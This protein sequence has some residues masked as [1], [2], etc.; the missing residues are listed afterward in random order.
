VA[1][2]EGE[3]S[4]PSGLR[5]VEASRRQKTKLNVLLFSNHGYFFNLETQ[6]VISSDPV[7]MKVI[8]LLL[9]APGGNFCHHEL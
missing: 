9:A 5:Q 6:M 8:C 1:F 3:S 4:R 7:E 2:H